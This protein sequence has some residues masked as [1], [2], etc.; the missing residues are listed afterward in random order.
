MR[1][2]WILGF[3]A[4]AWSSIIV[5]WN[6]A[7]AANIA[8]LTA[9]ELD[10]DFVLI[11][12]EIHAGDYNVFEGL[13]REK[14]LQQEECRHKRGV[15]C[16]SVTAD[17]RR[18]L[19]VIPHSVLLNSP[20]GDLDEAMRIGRLV[21][22]LLLD[23]EA[24]LE[25]PTTGTMELP[26]GDTTRCKRARCY[27]ASA[28]FFIWAGGIDRYGWELFVHQ[29]YFDPSVFGNLPPAEAIERHHQMIASARQYLRD[30][31]V[32]D[33]V[34]NLMVATPPHTAKK[35]DW[36][37]ANALNGYIPSMRDWVSARC[38]LA[39]YCK[40]LYLQ[41]YVTALGLWAPEVLK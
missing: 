39:T 28:C 9:G 33:D 24:A 17:G 37:M 10:C 23:T 5:D 30:M 3:L 22:K 35:L 12:G 1:K 27:C 13:L 41:R 32:T 15:N 11:T 21:R 29:P 20:G 36:Q 26:L 4:I 2:L 6:P 8:C 18:M 31:D 7:R 16:G 14:L 19:S 34:I 40:D 38:G 25:S